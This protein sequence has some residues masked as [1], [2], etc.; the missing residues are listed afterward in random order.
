[1]GNVKTI[2]MSWKMKTA[3]INTKKTAKIQSQRTLPKK[4]EFKFKK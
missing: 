2:K 3:H 1:M 4:I